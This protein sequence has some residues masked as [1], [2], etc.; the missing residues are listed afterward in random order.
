MNTSMSSFQSQTKGMTQHKETV[1]KSKVNYQTC[2]EVHP[3][4]RVGA[5]CLFLQDSRGI[6]CSS[7]SPCSILS[8]MKW[9][10]TSMCFVRSWNCRFFAMVMADWLSMGSTVGSSLGSPTS[11]NKHRS[12]T[13]P[14]VAWGPAMY[15]ASVLVFMLNICW[16]RLGLGINF[17]LS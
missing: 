5:L 16:R 9:C 13:S 10:R 6:Y 17:M 14:L 7:S 8:P 4:A 2:L 15:S 1:H 3:D 12:H 11:P